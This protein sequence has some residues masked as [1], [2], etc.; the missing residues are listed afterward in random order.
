MW[1][2]RSEES[3][4][5]KNSM[6]YKFILT[7]VNIASCYW[8]LY[9][10]ATY[11]AKRHPKIVE[12]EKAIEVVLRLQ[13]DGTTTAEPLDASGSA[14]ASADA[15]GRSAKASVAAAGGGRR[16]TVTALDGAAVRRMTAGSL[17]V[18]G[19]IAAM[20]RGGSILEEEK[21]HDDEPPAPVARELRMSAIGE[22]EVLDIASRPQ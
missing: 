8:S 7:M 14:I 6:P 18:G 1:I 17:G 11:F 5:T 13:D 21:N 12:S 10:Y 2:T 4:L 16:M 22:L 15:S 9:K 19:E 3:V 20:T